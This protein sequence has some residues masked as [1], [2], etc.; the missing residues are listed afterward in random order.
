MIWVIGYFIIGAIFAAVE[1]YEATE[2]DGK[3]YDE[4]L[5]SFFAW[6]IAIPIIIALTAHKIR[7]RPTK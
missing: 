5:L 4:V 6:P 7:N 2:I 1:G 3:L